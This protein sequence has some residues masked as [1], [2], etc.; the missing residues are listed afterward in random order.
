MASSERSAR[1]R[2]RLRTAFLVVVLAGVV[3]PLGLAGLWLA[4]TTKRSAETLVRGRL[5]ET[6]AE[7][8]PG[9][10]E[11]WSVQRSRL[12]ELGDSPALVEAADNGRELRVPLVPS[13]G[14]GS[15]LA[16]LRSRWAAL[17]G[18]VDRIEVRGLDG[19]RLAL[20]ERDPAT[21]PGGIGASGGMAGAL[22][23]VRLPLS[24]PAGD[25]GSMY[26]WIRAGALLP[27]D[28]LL[29][30]VSGSVLA[31]FEPG[32]G[33]PL[34]PLPM[35]PDLFG[36]G[37]FEWGGETWAVARRQLYEPPL[38]LALAGP[39]GAVAAPFQE[40]TRT[41]IFVL[42][43]VATFAVGLTVLVS[44]HLTRPLD[45]LAAA[46]ADVTGGRLD[47]HV[48]GD[49]PDEVQ[50]LAAAF[51]E[52]TASLRG[53]L[54]RLAHQEA[55]AA[56]GEIA[57]SMAHEVR[58]PLTAIRLDLERTGKRVRGDAEAERLLARAMRQL[59]RLDH[60]VDGALR[61]ARSGRVDVRNIELAG[62]VHAAAAA[63]APRFDA[64][65]AVLDVPPLTGAGIHVAADPHA[66]EQ[67]L[68]NLLLNAADALPP[69]GTAGVAIDPREAELRIV[70]HDDG[71]GMAPEVVA[72]VFEPF[73]STRREGTGLGLSIARR[74]ATTHG[75]ALEVDSAPGR[76]TRVTL[77]LPRNVT[78]RTEALSA[79][80]TPVAPSGG[81]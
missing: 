52:M 78:A 29:P 36:R 67:L 74:I 37:A 5:A 47:R 25:I 46:A 21:A 33:S 15:D 11:R 59:E 77:V 20:L 8:V 61:L 9:V 51:N 69:G 71:V 24:R 14:E 13:P 45:R 42:L 49:G 12:L 70:V 54:A 6:L 31:I 76:G 35:D 34:V 16:D 7:M 68:L 18:I 10:G 17:D 75:G 50:R 62:P 3:L 64:R 48:P 22:V 53:N 57:A 4:G 32:G 73:F 28:L 19:T 43:A 63:A 27:G 81:A 26:A 44:R 56:M 39:V 23:P 40:A 66:L 65:D 79:G 72:R 41:G 80:D 1:R 2:P 58:N 60:S 30:G 38:V 55:L